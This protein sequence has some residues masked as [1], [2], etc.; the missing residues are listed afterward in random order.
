MGNSSCQN[1]A[2]ALGKSDGDTKAVANQEYEYRVAQQHKFESAAELYRHD[3]NEC[4]WESHR[5]LILAASVLLAA[6][7]AFF[8]QPD[9]LCYL[10]LSIRT[11]VLLSWV[12]YLASMSVGCLFF[13]SEEGFYTRWAELSSD[14]AAK[15]FDTTISVAANTEDAV[16]R[17]NTMPPRSRRWIGNVQAILFVAGGVADVI[18]FGTLVF[19]KGF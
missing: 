5:Q 12:L 19:R 18:V 2:Q 3:T 4:C 7:G 16:V 14:I 1:G 11:V 15:Y 13:W 9:K 8:A 6:T 17:W 10:N